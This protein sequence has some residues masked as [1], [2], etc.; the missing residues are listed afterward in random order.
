MK[1]R[2]YS[3]G[4]LSM[5]LL[6]V[7]LTGFAAAERPASGLARA[8]AAQEA[9]TDSLLARSGVVGTA[10]GLD[11]NHVPV[12]KIYTESGTVTGLPHSL[13]GV[14]TDVEVTGKLVAQNWVSNTG[15]SSGTERLM[16]YR[17]SL[18]CTTGTLG[19]VVSDGSNPYAL[20][21]AHVY[22]LEGSKPSGTVT[23]GDNGDRALQ[24]GRVDMTAQ[25]CGSQTEIDAAAIGNL[26]SYVPI[27]IS[28]KASNTVDAAV[29]KLTTAPT[30]TAV[31]P[32]C[33]SYVPATTTVIATNG[34]PV[35][36]CGRT[37]GLTTGSVSGVNATVIISYDAGQARFVN[38]VVVTGTNRSAFS[39]GGDSGSLI[40]TNDGNNN[41]VALLFAGSPSTTIGNPI[42][43]VL[44]AFNVQI[45]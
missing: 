15:V 19:A 27:I 30:G 1:R 42:G 6:V 13:D 18:Y 34:M 35:K 36:K 23:T 22:A 45:Q 26:W 5:L 33:G 8:I 9:H 12:V 28:R 37:T 16:I 29:A 40:V 25:A 21:N 31:P 41:P 14:A 10:V 4:V 43:V 20:S 39:D 24:P 44:D 17:G 2:W 38:Q 32:A 3:A 11:A 7:A